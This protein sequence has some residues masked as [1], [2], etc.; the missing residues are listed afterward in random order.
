[1]GIL[2]WFKNRQGQYDPDRTSEELVRWAVDKAVTLINPRLKL[3]PDY[4]TRLKPAVLTTIGFLREQVSVLPAVHRLSAK[5]WA[6]D[7]A[8]RAFFVGPSDIT[9]LLGRSS[10]LRTFFEK[11]PDVDEACLVL[12]MA[13]KEQRTFGMALQGGM[14]QRD[15]AQTSA[16]FSDHRAR[17]C[18]RDE[19][20]LRRIVGVEVF[21]YLVTQALTEIGKEREERRELQDNRSLIKARLRLLKQHGPGLGSMF[22]DEPAGQGEQARLAAELLDNELQLEAL[23][24][25]G[26]MLEAELDGLK[27]VLEKPDRYLCF[28]PRQLQLDT[29]NVVVDQPGTDTASSVEFSV[30]ELMGSPPIQR[31]FILARVARSELP[32]PKKIDLDAAARYL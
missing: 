10:N 12:G 20:R 21:E 32:P 3:L 16:I 30:V 8:L 24:G 28:T 15:V 25:T 11:F 18:D 13:F 31:A 9:E 5:T 23:G 7:P 29:M 14:I 2:D 27:A 6:R 19:V 22:G 17:I 4:Y 26:D 1:M